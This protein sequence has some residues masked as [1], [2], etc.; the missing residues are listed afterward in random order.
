MAELLLSPSF[1]HCFPMAKVLRA[2]Y[3]K[4]LD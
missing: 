2:K 4:P 3:G 1:L